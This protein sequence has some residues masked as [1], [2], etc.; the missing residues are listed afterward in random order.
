MYFQSLRFY[1]M[2]LISSSRMTDCDSRILPRNSDTCQLTSHFRGKNQ[3][4]TKSRSGQFFFRF[5]VK[6]CVV[7][8]AAAESH[9]PKWLFSSR[10]RRAE[11]ILFFWVN[12]PV[13]WFFGRILEFCTL[14][15]S[16]QQYNKNIN[17]YVIDNDKYNRILTLLDLSLDL[18]EIL[19]LFL[20]GQRNQV[21]MSMYHNL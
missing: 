6:S 2:I 1:V 10:F 21:K 17:E 9:C 13:C 19:V 20:L 3:V 15:M 7:T 8:R 14:K 18:V 4:P 5:L 16:N 11:W 12:V